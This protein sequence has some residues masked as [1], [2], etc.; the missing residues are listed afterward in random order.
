[1]KIQ[2]KL[3]L[4]KRNFQIL[5]ILHLKI[6]IYHQLQHKKTLINLINI[7]NIHNRKN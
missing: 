5:L 4:F 6:L 1:M 2:K 7:F 3:F